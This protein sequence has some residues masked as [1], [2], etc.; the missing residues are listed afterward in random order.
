[1]MRFRV[2]AIALLL[3]LLAEH[4]S[5]EAKDFPQHRFGDAP[6]DYWSREPRDAFALRSE[7]V[8]IALNDFFAAPGPAPLSWRSGVGDGAWVGG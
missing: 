5:S 2:A 1:M 7:V 4:R 3:G 8:D 6:H